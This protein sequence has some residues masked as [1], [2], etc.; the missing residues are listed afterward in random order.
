MST[1]ILNA[2]IVQ[3]IPHGGMET[4]PEF[5]TRLA[6]DAVDIYNEADLWVDSL[7]D[8]ALA[9]QPVRTLATVTA[10]IARGIVDV[11]RPAD[12][13]DNPDGAI[14]AISSYGRETFAP[15]LSHEEKRTLIKAHWRPWHDALDAALRATAGEVR[16]LL[17]CHSMAQRGPTTYAYAGAARPHLCIAN[18]GDERGEPR[19][20][21]LFAKC[22]SAPAWFLQK[23]GEV[24]A[25]L[26]ADLPLLAPDGGNP[27]IVA[28]N[29]P[30]AG[31]YICK[32][33][34]ALANEGDQHDTSVP[35]RA[36]WSLMVEINR[37]LYVSAQDART[38]IA[39]PNLERIAAVR[40]RLALWT[41]ALCEYL[42]TP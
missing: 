17:D 5:H 22:L 19:T 36:P 26:F 10:S 42:P 23:A 3:S 40:D 2:L 15:S 39:P 32:R 18:L 35:A 29:W 25:D 11:N 1:A 21:G 9:A 38:P 20:Q 34:T 24:A 28:L 14:K 12:D 41:R 8:L 7:Y 13:L 27:P 31:G 37:G 6:I 16:L 33:Y 30:F 4:P